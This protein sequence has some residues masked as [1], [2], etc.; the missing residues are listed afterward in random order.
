MSLGCVFGALSYACYYMSLSNFY[1]MEYWPGT[2]PAQ[3]P[4]NN[5]LADITERT[6]FHDYWWAGIVI[7]HAIQQCFMTFADLFILERLASRVVESLTQSVKIRVKRLSTAAY[8]IFL[9]LNLASIGL[10]L[11]CGIYNIFAG[12]DYLRSS[13]A[14]RSGDNF[15]GAQFNVDANH[16]N[17]LANN[18][19]GVSCWL[20]HEPCNLISVH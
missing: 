1:R 16:F 18:V 5:Q 13:A 4:T 7:P 2:R 17:D 20:R 12:H 6:A 9:L 11:G 3:E 14:Y 15:T 8:V 10:M 19:Q